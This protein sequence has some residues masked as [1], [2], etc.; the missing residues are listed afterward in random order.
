MI[1]SAPSENRVPCIEIVLR[2]RDAIWRFN[3]FERLEEG[4]S[5]RNQMLEIDGSVC[6]GTLA[7]ISGTADRDPYTL[8][9]EDGSCPPDE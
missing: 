3:H 5:R 8:G 2:A 1:D 4:L 6:E 9:I 7:L